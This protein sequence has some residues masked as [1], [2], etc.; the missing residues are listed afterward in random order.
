MWAQTARLGTQVVQGHTAMMGT[1]PAQGHNARDGDPQ[2]AWGQAVR[3]GTQ[4]A[5]G[6]TRGNPVQPLGCSD[7]PGQRMTSS[8]THPLACPYSHMHPRALAVCLQR[9]GGS[10]TVWVHRG[11]RR[12][13]RS[14]P[15]SPS[16][17]CRGLLGDG[18]SAALP[19]PLAPA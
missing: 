17:L 16:L 5:W 7:A 11:R 13:A 3:M 6:H 14:L 12:H 9:A 15:A 18:H 1:L 8:I 4:P 19:I 2:T 10:S